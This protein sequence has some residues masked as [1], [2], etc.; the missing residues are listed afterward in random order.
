[1]QSA[2]EDLVEPEGVNAGSSADPLSSAPSPDRVRPGGSPETADRPQ[3]TDTGGLLGAP[4][5][6]T[7]GPGQRLAAG[8][9]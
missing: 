6:D 8:E 9:G 4:P 5:D 1:M 3:P 2:D 7:P